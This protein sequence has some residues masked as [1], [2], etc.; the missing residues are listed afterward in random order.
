[1]ETIAER[2]GNLLSTTPEYQDAVREDERE[3][4]VNN[5]VGELGMICLSVYKRSEIVY[6]PRLPL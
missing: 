5:L 6:A 2:V 3:T 1:M 4:L